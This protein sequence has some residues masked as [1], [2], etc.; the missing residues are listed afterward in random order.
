MP[1]MRRHAVSALFV[2]M[3]VIATGQVS[4]D[5]APGPGV[6]LS[7][8]QERATR[9]SDLRYELHFTIPPAGAH[10]P[11]ASDVKGRAIIRFTLADISRPLALDFA[12]EPGWALEVHANGKTFRAHDQNEHLLVPAEYLKK[13][14]NQLAIEFRAG[15]APLNRQ[16]EF[17]YTLFVPARARL[18]FPCFD[19]PDLKA[20]FSL[21]LDIPS[22]WVALANGDEIG[23]QI[24]GDRTTLRFAETKPVPTYLF[25]FAAGR[26]SIETAERNG[27]RFR[28]FH[29]ETD[30]AKVARNKDA[31]FDLHA[32]ALTWLEKYTQIDYPFGKFDFLL[33][34]SFQFSG[35]EH[36]GAIFYN[37]SGILLDPSATQNQKLGRA[38]VIAHETSHMWFGDLVTMRWFDDVW[39]KEVFA[40][41][42]AA[43]IVNPSFPEINHELR[44]LYAHYPAAY[45]VDRT[46]GTNPIRQRL[47]NLNEAGSLY[48][49]IIY[50][51]APIVM[52]QLEMIVG[53]TGLR[54]GLRQ[55]LKEHTYGN[56]AWTDLIRL[57]DRRTPEDLAGW[58]RA[59]VEEAGRPIVTTVV[60]D[61]ARTIRY[62]QQD[63]VPERALQWTQRLKVVRAYSN[64][65]AEML[66]YSLTGESK[67]LAAGNTRNERFLYLLPTGGGI[68]Y[69][70][71]V[72]DPA[73]RAYLT[74]HLA[75]VPDAL[76]RGAAL[77]TL[78]EEMLDARVTPD[79]MF[80]MLVTALPREA[81]ELN[82]ARM[83]SYT[84]Q[85]FW[86]FLL[87]Q[88]RDSRAPAIERLLRAGLASAKTSSLK[89]AW[90]NA[91]RDV[92]R[93]PETIQWLERVWR[94]A[95]DVPGLTLA[96]PDYMT[97]ALEL[98][99]REVL[100][101]RQI[102]DEQLTRIANPDRRAQF[103]FVAPALSADVSVRDAFVASL[104][105]VKNRRREAWVLQALGYVNHPLR[106]QTAERHIDTSLEMV[107]ELQR[108]GDIFFPRRWMDATLS[109][110]QSASAAY[111][112]SRFLESLPK[113]YP[114]RLR[115]IVLSSADDLFRARRI[116]ER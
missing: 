74:T 44:F 93:T 50:Q 114:D 91:V 6:P 95:E 86:K 2:V 63:P 26:F 84:Q 15:N 38:S 3:S 107:R 98:A 52:R 48:G 18:A 77:V 108:T 39:M 90:F 97:L 37:A 94:Q 82:V 89:S 71:F 87:P 49:A 1:A 96:E 80:D 20:R 75:E 85:L 115:R 33:V 16:P 110:H 23:R 47:D 34:P 40:N 30:V 66:D 14:Q 62:E 55:Y 104:R 109:G 116:L 101:A 29:R 59:W 27:R 32:A 69:G 42:M 28:M 19:Q 103:Q 61:K 41:F 9:L 79:A 113:D 105:D 70:D 64:A 45:A 54:D 68:G 22:E 58:S 53:T 31:V 12:P 106:A 76:T 35:M 111:K 72:L 99:V 43:K 83:L 100:S 88:D 24:R 78:W 13:G 73:S 60:D 8:A 5:G 25:A 56:A 17:M 46:P 112:V 4:H 81:D 65:S 21:T 67:P 10:P 51:K 11:D 36:A 7:L 102:L 92:A 57:L